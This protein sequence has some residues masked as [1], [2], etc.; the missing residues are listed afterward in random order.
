MR[1][2]A[3]AAW[4]QLCGGGLVTLLCLT[5][6]GSYVHGISQARKVEKFVISLSR[7]SSQPRDWSCLPLCRWILYRLSCQGS[8]TPVTAGKELTW[9]LEAGCSSAAP[10]TETTRLVAS[11]SEKAR[12][13]IDRAPRV[14][15]HRRDSS[16]LRKDTAAK[17]RQLCG[18][19]QSWWRLWKSSVTKAVSTYDSET[20]CSFLALFFPMEGTYSDGI[21]AGAKLFWTLC[22]PSLSHVQPGETPWTI[23][24]RAPLPMEFSSQKYW[25][26]L[27]FSTP[28]D[29]PKQGSN[30]RLLH[31]LHWQVGSLYHWAT[32]KWK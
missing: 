16:S 29:L 5:L 27:P 2:T 26:G 3:V 20:C 12:H 24:H 15:S 31:P 18:W 1:S 9:N 30:L 32:W 19:N 25:S 23:A 14:R 22:A 4:P 11:Q 28:G 7:G 21:S 13:R 8:P 10:L 6:P 17:T